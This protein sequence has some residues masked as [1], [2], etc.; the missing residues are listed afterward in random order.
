MNLKEKISGK[1]GG[2]FLALLAALAASLVKPTIYSV[3]K[4]I[5]GRGIRRAGREYI[6]KKFCFY[7][8]L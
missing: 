3:V 1:E 7:S 4:D 5:S 6:D 2:F 8:I